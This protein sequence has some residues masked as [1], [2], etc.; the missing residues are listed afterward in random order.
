MRLWVVIWH[1][2]LPPLLDSAS[3]VV[4]DCLIQ[5]PIVKASKINRKKETRFIRFHS[6]RFNRV[7]PSWR[8]PRGIDNRARRQFK[9]NRPLVK[10]GYGN[11]NA[12]KFVRK[13]DGFKVFVAQNVKDVEL[14]LMHNR[15]YAVEAAANLSAKTRAKIAERSKQLGLRMLA[16]NARLRKQ[17]HE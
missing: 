10:N 14:L 7:K 16:P 2:P 8:R 6:D 12:Y 4:R 5:V 3:C 9:G 17:E 15:V 13:A 11:E 1:V